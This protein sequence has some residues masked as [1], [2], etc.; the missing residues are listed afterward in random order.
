MPRRAIRS[1]VIKST[2]NN[3]DVLDMFQGVLGT[4]ESSE[5]D[6]KIAYPKYCNVERHCR[7]Y[8]KILGLLRDS[9]ALRRFSF[10][11]GLL[12]GYV[13]DLEAQVES[14]F[15]SPDLAALHPPPEEEKKLFDDVV[16]FRA[17]T[18]EEYDAFAVA[19]RAMKKDCVLVDTIITTCHN[20]ITHKKSLEDGDRLRDYFIARSPGLT[21]APLA[22]LENLNYKELYISDLL[23]PGDKEFLLLCLHKIYTISHDVYDAMSAPDVDVKAFVALVV[24]NISKVQAHIPGCKEAFQKIT[25]SVALLEGNF[26]GYYKDY[27]AT[28]NPSIILE[29]FVIDVSTSTSNSP[30]IKSQF[31]RIISHY[32]KLA[33]R[34]TE[35]PKMRSLFAQVDENFQALERESR[36]ADAQ[37]EEEEEPGDGKGPDEGVGEKDAP[38]G[39]A[40]A[41]PGKLDAE[42]AYAKA[43]S[44]EI[45]LF[46]ELD[47]LRVSGGAGG[48]AGD[49]DG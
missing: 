15:C 31:R 39:V 14:V 42:R 48:A 33:S 25:D 2:I 12:A 34:Q 28:D 5:F 37:E 22:G 3:K 17:V 26:A 19:Y 35:N 44:S 30:T 45:G 18:K 13:A 6:M 43:E 4:G 24:E 21:F 16:C 11:L 7:R 20:L 23:A 40:A 36:K 1:K 27:V 49:A 46:E 47:R 29:N 8:L 10:E 32:R 38:S 9:A 41:P